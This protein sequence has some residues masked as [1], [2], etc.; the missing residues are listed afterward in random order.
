MEENTEKRLKEV[1]ELID[2]IPDIQ[3]KMG[4]GTGI[5]MLASYCTREL[6]LMK[7]I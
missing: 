3:I 2:Q 6:N 5:K 1:S 4:F 7:N